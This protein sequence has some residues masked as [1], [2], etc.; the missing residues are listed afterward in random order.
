MGTAIATRQNAAAMGPTSISRRIADDTPKVSAPRIT[1][2]RGLFRLL[3]LADGL[4]GWC[5]QVS[6]VRH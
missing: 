1:S 4:A 3:N 2:A 5:K 6:L